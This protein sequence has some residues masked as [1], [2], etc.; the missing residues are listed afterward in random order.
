MNFIF[1]IVVCLV[2]RTFAR[3]V[4]APGLNQTLAAGLVTV[5]YLF[6]PELETLL[7]ACVALLTSYFTDLVLSRIGVIQNPVLLDD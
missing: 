7:M 6:W 4:R 3:Y 2:A 5:S 1:I